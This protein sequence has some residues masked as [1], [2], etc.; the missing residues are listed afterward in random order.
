MP[1][2][3]PQ[4]QT[5]SNSE[6]SFP[7]QKNNKN[8]QANIPCEEKVKNHRRGFICFCRL[9]PTQVNVGKM[10]SPIEKWNL[11]IGNLALKQVNSS[12][13]VFTVFWTKDL[14]NGCLY[15]YSKVQRWR[16]C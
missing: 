9:N 16:H 6:G 4:I 14:C 5:Q 8:R 3:R 2:F 1:F 11:I 12:K 15:L 7:P 10:D 13:T